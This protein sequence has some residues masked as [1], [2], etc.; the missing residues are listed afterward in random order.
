MAK[1]DFRQEPRADPDPAWRYLFRNNRSFGSCLEERR[2]A[3]NYELDRL[4]WEYWHHPDPK[5]S[6]GK[7]TPSMDDWQWNAILGGDYFPAKAY[8]DLP[9]ETRDRV[10]AQFNPKIL[11][12]QHRVFGSPA[13]QFQK[14]TSPSKPAKSTLQEKLLKDVRH[15]VAMAY[16]YQFASPPDPSAP[17]FPD[18]LKGVAIQVAQPAD[19]EKKPGLFR[20]LPPRGQIDIVSRT[21]GDLRL[22]REVLHCNRGRLLAVPRVQSP[23][24]FRDTKW[25]EIDY[26][27]PETYDRAGFHAARAAGV[28]RDDRFLLLPWLVQTHVTLDLRYSLM[29]NLRSFE[30][31]LEIL[32]EEAERKGPG[33]TSDL[34]EEGGSPEIQLKNLG[35]M[36]L[37][38]SFRTSD[39]AKDWLAS[40]PEWNEIASGNKK[41]K[42]SADVFTSGTF[43]KAKKTILNL[44]EKRT[45]NL[46]PT[47]VAD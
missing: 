25:V 33:M 31:E 3:L 24:L 39:A 27:D 44:L 1:R 9:D 35:L 46:L 23:V 15:V 19:Y 43:S 12:I 16:D 28:L 17:K 26:R 45:P 4:A 42:D 13:S 8:L 7:I 37:K 41:R 36:R 29:E 10:L 2:T 14:G 20:D 30:E 5:N 22:L 11:S 34:L 47:K 38:R 32:Y 21:C 6:T 18:I 40:H